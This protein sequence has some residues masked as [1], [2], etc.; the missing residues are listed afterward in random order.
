MDE[1][2]YN[3]HYHI[4]FCARYRRKIFTIQNLESRFIDLVTEIC[5]S[6]GMQLIDATCYT[7]YCYIIINAPPSISA[8]GAVAK[9][10]GYTGENY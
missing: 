1:K 4:V 10:K 3:P 9:I 5:Y 2:Y 8:A 6:N 7:D